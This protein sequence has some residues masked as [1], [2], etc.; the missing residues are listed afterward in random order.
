MLGR[1]KMSDKDYRTRNVI[2]NARGVNIN[3]L[4]RLKSPDCV[5]GFCAW[6][7]AQELSNEHLLLQLDN[8]LINTAQFTS[9]GAGWG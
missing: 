2:G 6:G 4:V 1:T 5:G 8:F 9:Y 3:K 7:V